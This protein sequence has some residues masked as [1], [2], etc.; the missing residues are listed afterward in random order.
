MNGSEVYASR[1]LLLLLLLAPGLEQLFRLIFS[2]FSK[3]LN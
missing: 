3:R 1:M 2:K